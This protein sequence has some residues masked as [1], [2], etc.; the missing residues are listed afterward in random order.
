MQRVDKNVLV[1]FTPIDM[2]RLVDH[3]E[4]YAQFLP[5]CRASHEA[6]RTP[7]SVLGTLQIEVHGLKHTFTTRNQL[8]P[9]SSIHMTLVEGPFSELSGN[10]EFQA[11]GPDACKIRLWLQYRFAS[12]LLETVIGPVFNRIAATLVDAF[13][14]EAHRRYRPQ[15]SLAG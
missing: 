10:W 13:V 7:D 2:Y 15:Q 8:S 5:W 11:I 14:A 9:P 12:R 1:P 6:N 3:I 4:Q